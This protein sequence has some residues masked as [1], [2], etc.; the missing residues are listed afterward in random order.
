MRSNSP[1][2][3]RVVDA[4]EGQAVRLSLG[5]SRTRRNGH[6][7][8]LSSSAQHPCWDRRAEEDSDEEQERQL[9]RMKDDSQ[10]W[11]ALARIG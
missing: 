5:L 2:G 4:G 1:G 6:V 10:G 11:G 8:V 7:E 9:G 3:V